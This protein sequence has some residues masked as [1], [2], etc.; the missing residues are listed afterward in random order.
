MFQINLKIGNFARVVF[1]SLLAEEFPR[2]LDTV[3]VLKNDGYV[4]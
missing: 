3:I 1:A 2:K 4:Y